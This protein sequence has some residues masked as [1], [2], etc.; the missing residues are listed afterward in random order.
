MERLIEATAAVEDRHFWFFGLRRNARYLLT[1][2]LGGHSPRLIVDCGAGT[3]RNLDWLA[4]FGPTVGVE[5]TGAGTD[6]GQKHG[7]TMIRGSILQLPIKSAA[8]DV[9]T[10][11]DVLYAFDDADARRI[12]GETRRILS[13][14]GIGL[15][16]VAALNVL[17]G[18]HSEWSYERH[19]Y[20]RRE[21]AALLKQEGFTVERVTFTNLSPFP[22]ALG[23]RW[24]ERLT[25]GDQKPSGAYLTV[26]PKPINVLFDAALRV[27]AGWLRLANL[28]I[29]TSLLAVVRRT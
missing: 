22:V 23:M 24:F 25:G 5:L 21:L 27:E 4:A 26:P 6:F 18:S 17:R 19:R 1:R 16:N 15:F 11:F 10:C 14:G 9:V 7:R 28:P 3:G 12:L 13:P 8:A 20:G 29:G 2:A